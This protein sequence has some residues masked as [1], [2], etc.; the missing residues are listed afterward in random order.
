LVKPTY[1][2]YD[3]G[4]ILIRSEVKV[5]YSSWDDRVRAFRA[6]G[7]Y[8]NEIIEFLKRS[9]LSAIKDSVEEHPPCPELK[10][11][12]LR[13]RTYQKKALDSWDKAGRRGVIVLPTGAGKTM[14]AMKAMELVNQ[15]SVVIVPT[16]DLL[17]QW[18]RRVQEEFDIEV[19]VYG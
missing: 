13:M 8:Y 9:E 4:S 17:E 16:L 12:S 1:L 10:C 2:S 5:P 7:L 15:S 6:Q 19:G 14:I 3:K 18:K 11:K